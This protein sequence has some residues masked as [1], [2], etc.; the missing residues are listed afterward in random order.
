MLFVTNNFQVAELIGMEFL[1]FHAV[2][3]ILA[4]IFSSSIYW[5]LHKHGFRSTG[6]IAS[7][8]VAW[9]FFLQ[10][11]YNETKSALV[12][13]WS[14]IA[15]ARFSET[16]EAFSAFAILVIISVLI[17]RICQN[18]IARRFFMFAIGLNLILS[19]S[20]LGLNTYKRHLIT[21]DQRLAI[22]QT[23]N[24]SPSPGENIYYIVPDGMAS[25]KVMRETFGLNTDPFKAQLQPLG[26]HVSEQAY[27][28]YNL[29]FLTLASVFELDYPVDESSSPYR[30][31]GE[32]YPSIRERQT[33]LTKI[34]YENGYQFFIA[35]P[36]WG[37][38]PRSKYYT[39]LTPPESNLLTGILGDY[40]VK[41]STNN[42]FFRNQLRAMYYENREKPDTDDTGKT[43]MHHFSTNPWRWKAG[44]SFTLIHM[45]MPHTPHRNENCEVINPN[46]ESFTDQGYTSSLKC[47]FTRLLQLADK[48][49][50]QDPTAHIIINADHGNY[51]LG[52]AD[53][54]ASLNRKIIHN[55]LSV[56]SAVRSCKPSETNELNNINIIRHVLSCAIPELDLATIPNKSYWGFY[57]TSP[58]FGK[59]R[60]VAP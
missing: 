10:F 14:L 44:S 50:T 41:T 20:I 22:N 48:I 19:T 47:V 51:K 26:F 16:G 17:A 54:F 55:R 2:F 40:A 6:L 3:S 60:Q 12:F 35:P 33:E 11:F 46:D 30:D 15:D 31:R 1:I 39:C 34:L 42:S 13:Y 5:T 49:T 4:G 18:A 8:A 24:I 7:Y 37:G 36:S 52:I 9:F 58:D 27:S 53:N 45:L 25:L 21:A 23:N 38:C 43:F 32:L 29:T 59:V 57:E 28:A 56:F